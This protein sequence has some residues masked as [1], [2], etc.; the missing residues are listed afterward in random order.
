MIAIVLSACLISNA[1]VCREHRIPLSTDVSPM[2]CM[3]TA[4]LQL[5]RW[6]EEHPQWRIVRWKCRPGDQEEI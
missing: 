1:S 6:S 5:A 3:I 4:Q 2:Q